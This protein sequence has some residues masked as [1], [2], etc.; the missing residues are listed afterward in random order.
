[1]ET[2]GDGSTAGFITEK[3]F[4]DNANDESLFEFRGTKALAEI[5]QENIQTKLT[6]RKDGVLDLGVTLTF[7]VQ[8]WFRFDNPLERLT[9]VQCMRGFVVLRCFCA[10][11]LCFVVV[12]VRKEK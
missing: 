2:D 10:V 1:M 7:M 11:L 5:Q 4:D 3:R 6:T 9:T 8:Y 12:V